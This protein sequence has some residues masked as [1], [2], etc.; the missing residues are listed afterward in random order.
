MIMIYV[1]TV[2]VT[3]LLPYYYRHRAYFRHRNAQY[4]IKYTAL[5]TPSFRMPPQAFQRCLRTK[6][7]L[8]AAIS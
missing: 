8:I 6:C 5:P 3:P 7:S 4:C 1:K 2:L